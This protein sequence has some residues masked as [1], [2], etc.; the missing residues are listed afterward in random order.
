MHTEDQNTDDVKFQWIDKV[1]LIRNQF[2]GRN[3]LK[4]IHTKFYDNF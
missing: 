1:S 4:N 2:H 3:I